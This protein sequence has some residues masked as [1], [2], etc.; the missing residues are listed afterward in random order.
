VYLKLY[1]GGNNIIRLNAAGVG[2]S[3]NL[4]TAA[5]TLST[6]LSS[7]ITAVGNGWYRCGIVFTATSISTVPDLVLNGTF[8]TNQGHFMWGAQVEAGAFATSYI[9]TV[10]SQVTRSPDA[11]SMTGTNFSS[12]YRQDEGTMYGEVVLGASTADKYI[13]QISDNTTNNRYVVAG[14]TNPYQVVVSNGTTT[15]GSNASGPFSNM[16]SKVACVYKVNDFAIVANAGTPVTD[17]LGAL[18]VNVSQIDLGKTHF[19]GNFLNVTPLS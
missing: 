12:W 18:P 8:G 6:A 16:T 17:T 5:I 15:V 1:A 2:A 10:A 14:T 7:S 19:V 4:S 11:A 13:L 9:P 3:F